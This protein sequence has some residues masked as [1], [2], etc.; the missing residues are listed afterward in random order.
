MFLQIKKVNLIF[1]TKEKIR[2]Y[3]HIDLI[4]LVIFN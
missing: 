2:S 3:L 1:V 4:K